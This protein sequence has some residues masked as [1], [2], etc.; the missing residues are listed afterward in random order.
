[1]ISWKTDIAIILGVVLG[2][3]LISLIMQNKVCADENETCFVTPIPTNQ[4]IV[5][6]SISNSPTC[7]PTPIT[8]I[9]LPTPTYQPTL[10]PIV[11]TIQPTPT[12][13]ES[14]TPTIVVPTSGPDTGRA[15]L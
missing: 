3:I 9:L 8:N 13:G 14:A 5:S 2:W 11:T 12:A 4:I 1:M 15:K 7:T 6:P 10:Q